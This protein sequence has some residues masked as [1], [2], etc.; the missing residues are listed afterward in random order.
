VYARRQI[1][2]AACA[3]G[4][5]IGPVGGALAAPAKD[6]GDRDGRA[7]LALLER[8]AKRFERSIERHLERAA[9]RERTA[10]SAGVESPESLGVSQSTLDAIAACESGGNPAAVNGAGYYGK[11]QFDLGT[12][13][14]VGGEGSP[15]EAAEAEQDYRAALLYS[16]AGSSPW[17]VCG[18]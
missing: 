12:W 5:A 8:P 1:A 10:P 7:K 13:Q 6:S 4:L 17:P 16:R 11:Y 14:S 2:A 9:R 15:A 18:A 3:A